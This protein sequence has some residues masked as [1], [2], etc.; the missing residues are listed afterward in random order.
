MRGVIVLIV[1]L[2]VKFALESANVDDN[3][4]VILFSLNSSRVLEI[5][6]DGAVAGGRAD[7]TCAGIPWLSGLNIQ[8]SEL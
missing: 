1:D 5:V 8:Q 4:I 2:R 6:V 3:T 7:L